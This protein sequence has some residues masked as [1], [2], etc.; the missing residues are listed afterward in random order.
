MKRISCRG[1]KK[2]KNFRFFQVPK[3]RSSTAS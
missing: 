2:E 3:M 1:K